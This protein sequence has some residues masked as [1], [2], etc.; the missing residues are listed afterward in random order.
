MRFYKFPKWLKRFYPNAIW[1]FFL[2]QSQKNIY[3]TFDDGP[4]P[5]VTEWVLDILKQY[6]AKAT[7]FCVGNN[8]KKHPKLYNRYIE[9]GHSVGNHTMN[10]T[11]GISTNTKIYINDVMEASHYIK[12]NL[13]RPPYGKCTPKQYKQLFKM[14]YQTIFWSHLYYD[15]DANLSSGE[16]LSQLKS[17]VKLGSI[18]VFHDSHKAFPQLKKELPQLLEFY[19]SKGY[20]FKAIPYNE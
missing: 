19:Q 5:M 16:R 3:L 9:E 8:V 11:K 6:N 10:H 7:F 18:I 13:F 20:Q 12:S 14:G 2:N 17:N 4:T 15:F 1:D